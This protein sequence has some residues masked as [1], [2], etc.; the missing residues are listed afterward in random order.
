[1][2]TWAEAHEAQMKLTLAEEAILVDWIKVQGRRGVPVT[3]ELL[4]NH[5]SAIAG[6]TVGKS[7]PHRFM[8]CHP[9][10][11]VCNSQALEKCHANNVNKATIDGFY[12][13]IEEVITKYNIPPENIY[14]MDEKG[15]Q[16]GVG[17]CIAAIIIHKQS[18]N[19]L[20]MVEQDSLYPVKVL[21]SIKTKALASRFFSY[22]PSLVWGSVASC[23]ILS[24]PQ[25]MSNALQIILHSVV[26]IIVI[27][28][29]S[30]EVTLFSL[31]QLL[32]KGP[33]KY[34]L[35]GI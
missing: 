16:L 6:T 5:A 35:T 14:N 7:W 29:V 31:F 25:F 9:D 13:I 8:K 28:W 27:F 32:G 1:M 2:K 11:L 18:P 19:S 26:M 21:V 20:P 4:I 34:E 30:V 22:L 33:L 15:I 24:R 10:I 3:Y 23:R 12:D 17:K